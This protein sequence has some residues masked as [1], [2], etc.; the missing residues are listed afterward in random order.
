MVECEM[1]K[2]RI[3]LKLY[4]AMNKIVSFGDKYVTGW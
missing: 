3:V 4:L 2:K 1:D